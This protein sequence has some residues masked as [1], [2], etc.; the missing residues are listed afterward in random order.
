MIKNTW[1]PNLALQENK[2]ILQL[3]KSLKSIGFSK[4][5]LNSVSGG[6][7][8]IRHADTQCRE[9]TKQEQNK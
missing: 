2:W 7:P 6:Q 4:A 9:G 3:D 5:R 1:S 8:Q